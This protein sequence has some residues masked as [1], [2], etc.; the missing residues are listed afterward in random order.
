MNFSEAL[1][2]LKQGKKVRRKGW[3]KTTSMS[4]YDTQFL[5]HEDCFQSPHSISY[6]TAGDVIADDWEEYTLEELGLEK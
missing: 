1:E 2:L 5:M 4:M 3:F 6:F